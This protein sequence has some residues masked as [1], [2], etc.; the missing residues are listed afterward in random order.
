MKKIYAP[1][2]GKI[3]IERSD[4]IDPKVQ[5]HGDLAV[6]PYNLVNEMSQQ[7]DGSG[8]LRIA[9]SFIKPE[10]LAR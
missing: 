3:K 8:T 10:I 5:C 4:M 2:A 1:L 9:W 7:P 6:L